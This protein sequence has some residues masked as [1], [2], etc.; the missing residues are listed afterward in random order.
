M[1]PEANKTTVASSVTYPTFA[2]GADL[3]VVVHPDGFVE[4]QSG[5]LGQFLRSDTVIDVRDEV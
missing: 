5:I 1:P 3:Y 4:F 2:H